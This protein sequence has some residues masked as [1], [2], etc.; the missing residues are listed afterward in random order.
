MQK[1]TTSVVLTGDI[2]NSSGLTQPEKRKMLKTLKQAMESGVT[3]M[4]D[5][6]PEIFQGD[7]F[8]GA[9]SL[10]ITQS[11]RYALMVFTLFRKQNLMI[12]IAL[13]LGSTV[14]DSGQVSTND[15]TAYVHSGRTL[16]ELKKKSGT[17]IGIK[18]PDE[19]TNLEYEVHC[20]SIDYLLTRCTPL[21]SEALLYAL[22]DMTQIQIAQKLKIS[23]PT[24]QQRLQAAGWP[25]FKA[26]LQ[27]FESK[28]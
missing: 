23:Q 11:L 1:Q 20:T 8:Q 7:S 18:T 5:W 6:K 21:Q 19:E 25:V 9:T 16:E 26:I 17:Y 4:P 24:V 28:Y 15:G 3:I 22:Q 10:G 14:F 27:R 2:V 12:R 13:G